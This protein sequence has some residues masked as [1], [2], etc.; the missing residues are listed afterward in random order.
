M[1]T[2]P[3][4]NSR[5]RVFCGS[6]ARQSDG[7]E[8][9]STSA[10][11]SGL[12]GASPGAAR[13]AIAASSTAMATP[14]ARSRAA[15]RGSDEFMLLALVGVKEVQHTMQQRGEDD[16]HRDDEHHAGIQ[17]VPAGEHLAARGMRIVDRS[18]AA[19]Q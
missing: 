5:Y 19:Q 4:L 3:P 14:A 10:V 7:A 9:A 6:S 16:A 8:A 12:C 13:A 18:H 15:G 11:V 17:G 1:T 2:R